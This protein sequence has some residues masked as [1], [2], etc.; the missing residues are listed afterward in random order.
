MTLLSGATGRTTLLR[1]ARVSLYY[2]VVGV[3]ASLIWGCQEEAGHSQDEPAESNIITFSPPKGKPNAGSFSLVLADSI[4]LHMPD[5]MAPLGNVTKLVRHNNGHYLVQ[6]IG[7]QVVVF[8][9]LGTYLWRVGEM[10]QGPGE[11]STN[12]SFAVDTTGV[13]YIFDRQTRRLLLFDSLR[14]SR[15]EYPFTERSVKRFVASPGGLVY[16]FNDDI[17]AINPHTDAINHVPSIKMVAANGS[18]R[19]DYGRHFDVVFLQAYHD[20]GGVSIDSKGE[21]VYYCY[22]SDHRIYRVNVKDRSMAVFDDKPSYFLA[23][24][25]DEVRRLFGESPSVRPRLLN[26]YSFDVSWVMGLE[27]TKRGLIFQ[28]IYRRAR[29][30]SDGQARG[31]LEVWN[32]SG[33]K[34]AGAIPFSQQM[35]FADDD[36]V[37]ALRTN[38]ISERDPVVYLYRYNW[39]TT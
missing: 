7:Q 15:S 17:R 23:P 8:D 16:Y 28:Q 3:A 37:Y 36:Y 18:S 14:V 38:Y 6:S 13:V 1:I 26:Q 20:G 4:E 33:D 10:G 30:E 29:P 22:L 21:C 34:V 27:I 9:S 25:T 19:A 12:Y 5:G 35:L 24:D 32:N 39:A 2:I 31:F 11:Y